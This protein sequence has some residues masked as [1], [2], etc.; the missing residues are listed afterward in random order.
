LECKI[1]RCRRVLMYEP[2]KRSILL[3]ASFSELRVICTIAEKWGSWRFGVI[4]MW[5]VGNTKYGNNVSK[6]CD[7][8]RL[9]FRISSFTNLVT[10]EYKQE[11]YRR[12]LSATWCDGTLDN[13]C[14]LRGRGSGGRNSAD[15]TL[16][17]VEEDIITSY[18]QVSLWDIPFK[19]PLDGESVWCDFDSASSLMCGNKMPSR[20][21]RWFLLQILLLA[22]HVSGTAMPIIRRN[23]GCCLW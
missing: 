20:C 14:V 12:R 8:E 21:N 3:T 19:E 16:S 2:W 1:N 17:A 6:I 5:I 9:K 10:L 13:L 22:Q 4:L 15:A 23:G 11:S 7:N 18:G